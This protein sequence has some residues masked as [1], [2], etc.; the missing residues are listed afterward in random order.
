MVLKNGTYE[1]NLKLQPLQHPHDHLMKIW[2]FGN[3]PA[4]KT[5]HKDA[6][7]TPP[8]YICSHP[9]KSQRPWASSLPCHALLHLPL[10]KMQH[11]T[12]L[13]NHFTPSQ[14]PFWK[15]L[16]FGDFSEGLSFSI[17]AFLKIPLFWEVMRMVPTSRIA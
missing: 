10:L 5:N 8:T 16:P 7:T 17:F 12:F 3:L 1:L 2:E 9:F 14:M 13:H 15:Q 6:V 11:V 4:L